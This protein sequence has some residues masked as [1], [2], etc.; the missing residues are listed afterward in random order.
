MLYSRKENTLFVE[1]YRP[2]SIDEYIGNDSFKDTVKKYIAKNDIPN[3]ILYGPPGRGKTTAAKLLVQNLD[4]EY[5]YINGSDDNGIGVVRNTIKNFASASTLKQLKIVIYDDCTTL[6]REAQEG[7]LNM[8]ETYSKSTRFIF[9]TNHVENFIE[10]L[11]SRCAVQYKIEPPSKKQ[12]AL[13]LSEILNKENI[14]YEIEDVAKIVKK[15]YPDIRSCTIIMQELIND[16]KLICDNFNTYDKNYLLNILN[17]LQHPTKNSWFEIRQII[18]NC[19][20]S[21]YKE[22]YKFLYENAELFSKN[23][24]AEVVIAISSAQYQDVFVPDKEINIAAL[25]LT[26]LKLITNE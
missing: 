4:C 3:M 26:I 7:L 20:I 9:T 22:V 13:Y 11:K 5:I 18:L 19:D 2:R 8:I 23:S 21:D 17:I 15:Y 12:V 24:Y 10:A 16:G 14:D 6:T 1:K 25:F